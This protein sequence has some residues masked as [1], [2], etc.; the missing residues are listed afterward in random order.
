MA[1]L[2]REAE[3]VIPSGVNSPVRAFRSVGGTPV[4]MK[5]GKGPLLWD[6]EGNR[7][8][9]FCASWGPML[10][11]H[12]PSGLLNRVARE[13]KNGTSFGTATAR[14]VDLAKQIRHFYPAM[15]KIRLVS[16]G[17]EAV[18]SAVRLARGAT[19]RKKIV[20]IDGGYHGHVDS[21]L[22]QA[23]SG[24]ATFGTP[25]SAGVPEELARL[26]VS[27]PFNDMTSL[28][29][30]FRR[31]GGEVA[32]VILEPVPA[33]MGVVPPEEHY[34]ERLC[35]T[36]RDH[37]ALVIFDEVITGFRLAEGGAQQVFGLSPDLT[38]LGKILG[39]GFPIAA[40]G[41]RRDLMDKLAPAG[42]VYQAG[43]LSGNPAA[44]TAALWMLE[45][46]EKENPYLRLNARAGVFYKKIQTLITKNRWPLT[47]NTMGSMFTL[48]FTG[49]PVTDYRSAKNSDASRYAKFFHACLEQ[50]VYLAPSQFEANFIS[51]VH[52][53][54]QLDKAF[55]I[56]KKAL[57]SAFS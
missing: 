56:F 20:K 57:E 32:A 43:T 18:M 42:P 46:I 15:K 55:V 27:V 10:F 3:K 23:G 22:V 51:T 44:V 1:S 39:G 21:L 53:P 9:D 37:G 36:A 34:L 17:T 14:E 12:A 24:L 11:G 5:R 50:G 49:K 52:T 7:Y 31:E 33:N 26:T 35:Q 47:L 25:D 41:G 8:L 6:E 13:I 54:A 29:A 38:C 19:G 40:F 30:L 48:F 28:Q 2:F 45:R 16:S 4:F